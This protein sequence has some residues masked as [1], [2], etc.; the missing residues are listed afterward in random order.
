[1]CYNSAWS[2]LC[3]AEYPAASLKPRRLR[4]DPHCLHLCPFKVLGTFNCSSI[5]PWI[6]FFLQK[7][8]DR[9]LSPLPRIRL[10]S[11]RLRNTCARKGIQE[12]SGGRVGG[13]VGAFVFKNEY[14]F[15]P[16]YMPF[17]LEKRPEN[18]HIWGGWYSFPFVLFSKNEPC[19]P[20]IILQGPPLGG[21]SPGSG[22]T[23]C[24]AS[25]GKNHY[26]HR[27]AG[28]R[29]NNL[30]SVR[31]A[32]GNCFYCLGAGALFSRPPSPIS[33]PLLQ[34]QIINLKSSIKNSLLLPQN[35]PTFHLAQGL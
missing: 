27:F 30:I 22:N 9:L 26:F 23:S 4:I 2:N 1:M 20:W 18:P 14:F 15:L 7:G 35:I 6:Q 8:I 13:G 12:R 19:L 34:S 29:P 16:A 31:R 17:I 3:H 25:H 33:Y 24:P 11:C 10:R 5:V 28:A 32:R 21:C